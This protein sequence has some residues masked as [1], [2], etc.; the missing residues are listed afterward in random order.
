MCITR[1]N[2]CFGIIGYFTDYI[3]NG[4]SICYYKAESIAIFINKSSEFIQYYQNLNME[5]T[6]GKMCTFKAMIY[7]EEITVRNC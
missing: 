1:L 4:L 5:S 2:E 7:N 3:K 6:L